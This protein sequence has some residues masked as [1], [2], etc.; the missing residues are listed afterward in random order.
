M[1]FLLIALSYTP[2]MPMEK[3]Y[4]YYNGICRYGRSMHQNKRKTEEDVSFT[5]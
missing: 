5:V 4:D 1:A 2:H 3:I